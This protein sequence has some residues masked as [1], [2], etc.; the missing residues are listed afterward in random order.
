[1]KSVCITNIVGDISPVPPETHFIP[2]LVIHLSFPYVH[3]NP[4]SNYTQHAAKYNIPKYFST[5][6][7]CEN[8]VFYVA[9]ET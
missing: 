1:M 6:R 7:N 9:R 8:F 5:E 4:L 3:H 2:S